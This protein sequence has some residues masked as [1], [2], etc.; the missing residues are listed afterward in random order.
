MNSVESPPVPLHG[1]PLWPMSAAAYRTLGDAGLAPKNTELLYGF[2]HKK[3][4][5]SPYHS[6]LLQSLHEALAAVLL[7]GQL[8]R[9]EQPISCGDSEPEPD[10]ALVAGGKEDF[11]HEHPASAELVIE[12][13]IASYDYDLAK[14]HA[15]ANAG[16]KECWL[17]L[18][19][20][21]KIA[22][23]RLPKNGQFMERV[24]YGPGGVIA[25]LALPRFTLSLDARF[26]G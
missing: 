20:E 21:K 24:L 4:S 12:I 10:L 3:M 6:F 22:A 23:Y 7:P 26:A 2:V 11:R 1:A 8:L 9:T 19:V 18:A 15:Y 13:S 16:V 25:S 5:K 14:L 17:V